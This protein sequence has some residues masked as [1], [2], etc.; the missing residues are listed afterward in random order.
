MSQFETNELAGKAELSARDASQALFADTLSANPFQVSMKQEYKPVV[1]AQNESGCQYNEG[2]CST[3]DAPTPPIE[4]HTPTEP[5]PE[6]QPQPESLTY[7]N[8]NRQDQQQQ[9]QQ[10]QQ[11]EQQQRQEQLNQQQQNNQQRFEGNVSG[12]VEGNV[13]GRVENHLNLENNP[14]NTLKN[15]VG[16]DVKQGPVSSISGGGNSNNV[17]KNTSYANMRGES[18]PGNDCQT[19]AARAD[20]YYLGTGGGFGIS[21]SSNRC[22]EA[23]AE[24]VT[25]DAPA[26]LGIAN[27]RNTAAVQSWMAYANDRQRSQIIEHGMRTTQHIA[28]NVAA[29]SD[30]CV[31]GVEGGK[32]EAPPQ[33]VVEKQV[34][35]HEPPPN[36]ATQQDLQEMEQRQVRR[37]DQAYKH[38]LYK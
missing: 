9:Q 16:V 37:L 38:G 13:S 34:I 11:Q 4:P 23:K 10:Q 28:D 22:I 7:N 8:D 36:M 35:V 33:A 30:A 32:T 26:S 14:Q 5:H 27:E 31:A 25:C 24:K 29:K 2:S 15:Q 1:L 18:L 17:Y 12:K 3:T 21:N 6:P 20:G 19:F